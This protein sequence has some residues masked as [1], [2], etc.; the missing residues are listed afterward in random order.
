MKI[1]LFLLTAIL[2]LNILYAQQQKFLNT[3]KLTIEDLQKQKSTIKEDAPAEVLYRSIHYKVGENYEMEITVVDRVKIYNKDKA[4]DYLNQEILLHEAKDG[5]ESRLISL[6]ANTYNLEDGKMV[7][8]KVEKDSRYKSV[9]DKQY[10]IVK[11]AFPNV[12]NG[13]VVEYTYMVNS[14]FIFEIPRFYVEEDV[15]IIYTEYVFDAPKQLGYSLNYQGAQT[16]KYR[17]V[18][19]RNMYGLDYRTTRLGYENLKPFLEEKFVKN[20]NNYKTSI[21][22][23]LNSTYIN[24]V[25]KSYSLAWEDVRKELMSDDDFGLTLKRDG[26]IKNL[27]PAEIK[28]IGN[29]I[30]RAE[31]VLKFVQKKYTWNEE[32]DVTVDKGVK[33]LISTGMG[34]AAEINLLLIMLLR[35]ANINANPVVLSTVNRGILTSYSPSITRLNYVIGEFESNNKMYLLDATSKLSSINIIP[36]RAVNY[37]GI[38]MNEKQALQI[39]II[40]PERSN[41]FLEVNAKLLNDGTFEGNFKDRDTHVF[42]M[43]NSENYDKDKEG[44]QKENYKERY[45]FPFTNIKTG[46]LEN[47]DF[48]TSFDFTSDTFVDA[49]GG[50]FIF[51]PLLFLYSQSH[52]FNQTEERVNPIEF[53]SAYQKNK[54]VIIT[55]PDGYKFENLPKSKK[56][57]TDDEYIQYSYLVT[58]EGNKVTVETTVLIDDSFFPKEY[59]PAFKQIFDAITQL[60]GQLVT[61]VKK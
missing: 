17:I 45:K 51:N 11:F 3:P 35:D 41:T 61:I 32:N 30:Q 57:K 37:T 24:N 2:G 42:A 16:P 48:E 33:N 36:P 12:K 23:E 53:T 25:F 38:L 55:I 20:I 14:P 39:D 15:P 7:A 26:L 10:N 50:K 54:K 60:E 13:S 40:N 4:E 6:K 43:L 8:T 52:D 58:Q 18:E 34:N 9:E 27:L 28:Q 19:E 21:R 22:E 56:F 47:K 49:V 1:K 5:R 29:E 59:Y 44:Y 46:L 31:A